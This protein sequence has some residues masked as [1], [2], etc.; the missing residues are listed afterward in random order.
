MNPETGK[1]PTDMTENDLKRRIESLESRIMHQDAAIEELT[2]TL[3]NQEQL[4]ARQ[5]EIIK[6]LEEQLRGLASTG[7]G[8]ARD[9]PPPPHY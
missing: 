1:N 7:P 8:T 4:L 3:L 5:G 6:R 9:E 2:H